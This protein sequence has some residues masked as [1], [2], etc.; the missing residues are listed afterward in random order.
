MNQYY[1]KDVDALAN[2]DAK[3]CHRW[4]QLL[5]LRHRKLDEASAAINAQDYDLAGKLVSEIFSGISRGR[6]PDPGMVV[7]FSITWLW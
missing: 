1:L 6:Q 5:L 4:A 2:F 7:R 3:Q